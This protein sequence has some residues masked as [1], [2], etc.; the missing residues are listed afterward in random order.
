MQGGGKHAGVVDPGARTP[1]SECEYIVSLLQS[2]YCCTKV[3][4]KCSNIV[5]G[6]ETRKIS[7]KQIKPTLV[8]LEKDSDL[9][10]K[11][12]PLKTFRI[13]LSLQ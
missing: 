13:D 5:T 7:E 1:I 3:L 10:E 9:N 12:R 11:N 6:S 8:S 2:K 4:L